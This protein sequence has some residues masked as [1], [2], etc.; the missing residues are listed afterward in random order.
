MIQSFADKRLEALFYDGTGYRPWRAFE[1][2]AKRKLDILDAATTL[3]DLRSPP[4][5]R[6]ERLRGDRAGQY[7]IRINDQWRLCFRWTAQGP[8]QVDIVDYH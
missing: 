7:S 8:E 2:A 4:G 1:A 3:D 5:N 6:L